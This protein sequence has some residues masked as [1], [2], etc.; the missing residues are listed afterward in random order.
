MIKW[1]ALFLTA[2]LTSCGT[3]KTSTSAVIKTETTVTDVRIYSGFPPG[4][5]NSESLS[6]VGFDKDGYESRLLIQFPKIAD[7]YDGSVVLSSIALI[8]V[9][10]ETTDVPVNPENI[11]MYPMTKAWTGLANWDLPFPAI[12]DDPWAT[13][14][15]DYDSTR[16]VNAGIRLNTK[17]SRFKEV[18]FDV[19]KYV[20]DMVLSGTPNYG[21]IVKVDKSVNNYENSLSFSTYNSPINAGHPTSVLI[22]NSKDTLNQ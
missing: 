5:Y 9:V 8:E 15:G 17:D 20:L 18:T 13:A 7:L 11:H 6:G 21:F 19:T 12:S 4:S 10:I 16:S 3:E 14:G 22:Y 1:T 2:F